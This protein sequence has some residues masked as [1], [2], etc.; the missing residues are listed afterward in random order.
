MTHPLSENEAETGPSEGGTIAATTGGGTTGAAAAG[1]R[2][3]AAGRREADGTSAAAA[4]ERTTCPW[5]RRTNCAP[6]SVLDRLDKF[7]YSS[8]SREDCSVLIRTVSKCLHTTV[9]VSDTVTV[10]LEWLKRKQRT[11]L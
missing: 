2:S 4:G 10:D 9:L 8:A 11:P 6:R 5:Q 7:L 1:A 3:G